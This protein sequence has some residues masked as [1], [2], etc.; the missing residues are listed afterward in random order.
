MHILDADRL[1]LQ[2]QPDQPAPVGQAYL[3]VDRIGRNDLIA[4]LSERLC[5]ISTL[6]TQTVMKLQP[7]ICLT[8]AL[9]VLAVTG[10]TGLA[11]PPGKTPT[12]DPTGTCK[13]TPANPGGK[14]VE[15][16]I[17][18]KLQGETLT[19]TITKG[20]TTTAITNG[21]V[22]GDKISFQTRKEA[23]YPKGTIV[24]TTY[25]GKLS[26]DTITGKVVIDTGGNNF[27]DVWEARRI[28]K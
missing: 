13:W 4:A 25:I 18:L 7:S 8:A 22:K 2:R 9:L 24:T 28:K 3:V 20:P 15:F 14:A 26:G 6:T 11:G 12:A 16:T 27:S 21:V 23:S 17:T 10:A 1:R 5:E 19:G